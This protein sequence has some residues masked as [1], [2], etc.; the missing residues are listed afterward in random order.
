MKASCTHPNANPTLSRR[1]L[2][3]AGGTAAAAAVLSSLAGCA[4]QQTGNAANENPELGSMSSP[5]ESDADN[6]MGEDPAIVEDQ[7]AETI[8]ADVIVVGT[9]VAGSVAACA[10]VESG[11]S[12]IMLD[13]GSSTISED[14]PALSS[15]R[16]SNFP[17][18]WTS[19]I[20]PSSS[21]N[22]CAN[23]T[24]RRTRP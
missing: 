16:N 21:T 13:K 6:W 23:R 8:E 19:T 12:V 2:M 15:T 20:P 1:M 14:R 10:A 18:E 22:W 9:G 24:G 3:G 5:A 17:R 4:T 11:A 7:I